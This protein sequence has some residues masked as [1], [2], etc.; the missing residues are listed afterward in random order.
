MSEHCGSEKRLAHHSSDFKR[1]LN[2]RLKRIEGQ[3]RGIQKLVEQDV[4]CDD[5][6]NQI[7][8]CRSAL[9]SV[10]KVLFEAHLSSCVLEQIQSGTPG[11][12]EELKKTIDIMT[13]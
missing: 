5:I 11:I 12:L 9:A 6:I 2:N 1:K 10:S 4:Y 13:K 3:I 8:A 7:S